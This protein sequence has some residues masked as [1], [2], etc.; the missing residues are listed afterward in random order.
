MC[1]D[2]SVTLEDVSIPASQVELV[3]KNLSVNAEDIRNMGLIPGL[4]KSP[5]EGMVTHSSILSWR[6]SRTEKLG[7]LRSIGLQIVRHS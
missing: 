2:F 1:Q 4:G 6:T 3:V 5:G 7:R